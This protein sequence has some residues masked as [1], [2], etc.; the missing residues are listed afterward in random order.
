MPSN[1]PGSCIV[2]TPR[3]RG[4]LAMDEVDH[5]ERFYGETRYMMY[6]E[7]RERDFK[8]FRFDFRSGNSIFDMGLRLDEEPMLARQPIS[9][10][11]APPPA[12]ELNVSRSV[13]VTFCLCCDRGQ[14]TI[15]L[16]AAKDVYCQ[17]ELIKVDA[18]FDNKSSSELTVLK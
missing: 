7:A 15:H 2:G 1:V 9:V 6:A 14:C 18:K 5:Y 4:W 8:D 10:V 13:Q 3:P 11:Q 16:K 17:G 12:K